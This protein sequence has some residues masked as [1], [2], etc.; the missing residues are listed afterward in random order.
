MV[1]SP[2]EKR[3]LDA[4][5]VAHL[6][7][8]DARGVPHVAPVCF[9]VANRTL[10]ITIDEKPKR[11]SRRSLKRLRNIAENP[12]V[13]VVADRYDE[14]WTRLGWVMLQGKAELLSSGGA[15]HARAQLLLRKRYR[16]LNAMRIEPLPVIAVRVEHVIS[17]GDLSVHE[18]AGLAD[19]VN[20]Q[21]G[22]D[23]EGMT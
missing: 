6:A 18:L 17:W 2:T 10:Y 13:A 16:Q 3:F 11:Q 9:V 7:T 12:A 15:E 20:H 5:R 23:R 22:G 1:L 8:A 4:R 21:E 19:S 14:D